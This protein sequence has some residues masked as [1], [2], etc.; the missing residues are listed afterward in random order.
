MSQSFQCPSCGAPLDYED[1]GSPTIRCPFCS[2]SVIV[3]ETL[4][5]AVSVPDGGWENMEELA[6]IGRLIRSGQKIEAIRRYREL[7]GVGLKEAKDAVERLE[8]GE[9]VMLGN[10]SGPDVYS[11]GAPVQVTFEGVDG[12]AVIRRGFSA[13]S[14][15]LLLLLCILAAAGAFAFYLL[16][17]TTTALDENLYR[18]TL[19]PL[20]DVP[21]AAVLVDTPTAVPFAP[22]VLQFGGRGSGAGLFSDARHVAVDAQGKI[23]VAEYTGGR[24]QV[25]DAAGKFLSQWMVGD[26]R[27]IIRSIAVDRKGVLYVIAGG[28]IYRYATGSNKALGKWALKGKYSAYEDLAIAADG[29]LVAVVDGETLLRLDANGKIGQAIPD[30]VSSVT[31]DSE[32]NARLAVGG[33]GDLYLLASFNNAVFHFAPTGKYINRFGSAGDQAGQ[34]RAPSEVVVDGQGRIYVSDFKGIQVFD[35]DGRYLALLDVPG[36]VFGMAVN[37]QNNLYAVSN[38]ERLYQYKLPGK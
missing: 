37:D 6:D 1:G 20:T 22:L 14:I 28:D 34:L 18:K 10:P 26:S 17:Q 9:A 25:F 33:K 2:T 31:G 23:Y 3:P 29:S 30:A 38:T 12:K 11:A 24:V 15:S 27:T 13:L 5:S 21:A 19:L 36:V 8:R 7:A 32:L 35:P 4:R 16:R